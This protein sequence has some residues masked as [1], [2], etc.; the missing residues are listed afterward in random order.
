[1]V[2]SILKLNASISDSKIG[3]LRTMLAEDQKWGGPGSMVKIMQFLAMNLW[4]TS[5]RACIPGGN[6]TVRYV[7]SIG[8]NRLAVRLQKLCSIKTFSFIVRSTPRRLEQGGAT[9]SSAKWCNFGPILGRP[10][11]YVVR[12]TLKLNGPKFLCWQKYK[13]GGVPDRW[14]QTTSVGP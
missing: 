4:F 7:D 10:Q 9:H 1:M 8:I 14:E 13:N 5:R 2:R 3:G 12:S 6:K 11:T